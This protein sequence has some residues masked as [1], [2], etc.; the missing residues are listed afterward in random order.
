MTEIRREEVKTILATSTV[1]SK[2]TGMRATG[3]GRPTSPGTTIMAAT[4]SSEMG[5]TI[6][7]TAR[8]WKTQAAEDRIH[9]HNRIMIIARTG[10]VRWTTTSHQP[11]TSTWG[12]ATTSGAT[13][14]GA[15]RSTSSRLN[16]CTVAPRVS[17]L[18]GTASPP[19]SAAKHGVCTWDQQAVAC[20]VGKETGATPA[21]THTTSPTPATLYP[22]AGRTVKSSSHAQPR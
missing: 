12:K 6:T 8:K 18:T 9:T 16:C 20:A 22:A 13:T 11:T 2:G 1:V 7:G 3:T 4:T 5:G 17:T 14:A 21:E 10:T 15:D 19:Q